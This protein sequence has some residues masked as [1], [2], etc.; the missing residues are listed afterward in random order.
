MSEFFWGIEGQSV[1]GPN[2]SFYHLFSFFILTLAL[3]RVEEIRR[4]LPVV[5]V[6]FAFGWEVLEFFGS[7]FN[8]WRYFGD[9]SWQNRLI[10]DPV[11]DLMGVL[12]AR[13]MIWARSFQEN[14]SGDG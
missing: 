13:T 2:Y 8:W 4:L 1:F 14:L 6:G 11:S 3:L 5:L 7:T 10:G 12:A 9:E